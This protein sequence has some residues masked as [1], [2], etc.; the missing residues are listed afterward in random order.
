MTMHKAKGLEFDFVLLPGLGKKSKP[1]EQ[2]LIYWMPHGDKLLLAPIRETGGEESPIYNFLKR[3]NRDK[4]NFEIQRLLYVSCTRPKHQLHLFGHTRQWPFVGEK[5]QE[6]TP[7]VSTA[8]EVA[9]SE[10]QLKAT[11][12]RLPL[13]FAI[14]NPLPVIETGTATEISLEKDRPTYEWAGNQARCL[15]NVLHRHFKEMA[16][17]GSGQW[18]KRNGKAL[19]SNLKIALRAEGLSPLEVQQASQRGMRALGNI[20]GHDRGQWVLENHQDSYAEFPLTYFDKNVF[21]NRVVDRTFVDENNVRWI[22]DYK[23]GERQGGNLEGFF[24]E[25][26]RRY[27]P[28]LQEYEKI[29]RLN[30]ESRPIKKALYYPLHKRLLEITD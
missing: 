4:E 26:I 10:P 29:F 8:D 2:Q 11:L 18:E 16:E 27:R 28:Q 13:D 12:R 5:W 17:S 24:R 9:E 14:P 19:E 21:K 15:G 7:S 3:I 22:I 1:E 25:E 23:T 30:G 20:L 6:L